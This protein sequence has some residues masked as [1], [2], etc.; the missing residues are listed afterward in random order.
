[1]VLEVL[2][3]LVELLLLALMEYLAVTAA[4]DHLEP[5]QFL[6][7]HNMPLINLKL[8]AG[9]RNNGTPMDSQGRWTDGSLVR[10]QQGSMRPVGGWR[11]RT[12]SFM[13]GAVRAVLPW[14][15]NSRDRWIALADEAK[16]KVMTSAGLSYDIT[17]AGLTVGLPTATVLTG[18]GNNTYGT[19]L[20][21][22][23]RPDNGVFSEATTW[24]LDTYGQYLVACSNADGK[25]YEW[26]LNT[27]TPAA[28]IAN[29]PINCSGLVVT[30]ERQIMA[31]GADGNPRKIAWCDFEDNTVWTAASTNQAGDTLLQSAGEIMAGVRSRGQTVILTTTD[32]WAATYV[33]PPFV[34][35]FSQ[36]GS[37]CGIISRKA[38]AATGDRVFW[39]SN[40]SFMSYDG[41]SVAE[42]PCEV[43][44]HVFDDINVDQISKCWAIPNS[45]NN[46]IWFFYPSAGSDAVDS[47]VAYDY[48]E[49]HW[50]IGKLARACGADMGVMPQP[51]MVCTAGNVF[52]HEIGNGH[53]GAAVYATTGPTQIANGD[54][55]AV[56]TRLIPD[57]LNLGDVNVSF[58]TRLYPNAAETSH[59]PYSMTNP[60]S[61]RLNGRQI[62]M[63]VTEV[64]PT[65]WRV[66]GMSVETV[67]GSKR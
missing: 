33:G 39:M 62:T 36:I 55:L 5:V 19:S 42:V 10:W 43:L 18:Y 67:Q 46:E 6:G 59:G 63:T 24:S 23:P 50:L 61:V 4:Q 26:Q 64:N 30:G 41:S 65:S 51:I 7:G 47:Y 44:D 17:P 21:G 16:L 2:L 13:S 14:I 52:D 54:N 1:V 45:Q 32:A 58:T 8:P 34:F 28:Q 37:A 48:A 53:S 49:N 60:T 56:I 29:S 15:D 9:F 22:Q 57:E 40:R 66:G 11:I 3:V 35:Q 27:A 12:A 38:I 31:L 25:L 20:Y